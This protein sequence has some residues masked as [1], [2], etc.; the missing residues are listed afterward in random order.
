MGGWRGVAPA[1][2][3]PAV[4]EGLLAK[5]DGPCLPVVRHPGTRISATAPSVTGEYF[6]LGLNITCSLGPT[7]CRAKGNLPVYPLR[8]GRVGA[9]MLEKFVPSSL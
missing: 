9:E 7:T 2:R 8:R 1:G 4:L 5:A 3:G 6:R